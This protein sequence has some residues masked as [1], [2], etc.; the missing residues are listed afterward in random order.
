M[1]AALGYALAQSAVGDL[2]GVHSAGIG[3]AAPYVALTLQPA[4][5]RVLPRP[6]VWMEVMKQAVAVP[7]FAT[8]IWLAWV[9]AQAYGADL[10][11][12]LLASFPAA[13]DCG[14]VPG[15]LAGKGVGKR[16]GGGGLAG[17]GGVGVLWRAAGAR[18]G[19]GSGWKA[20]RKC[21][22]ERGWLGALVCGWGERILW[23]RGGRCL[24]TLPRAG[25]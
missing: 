25:A 5:T 7:I 19:G 10:L 23:R 22:C 17:S 4:W 21:E 11:A 1:G 6:G 15:A 3:V 9:L 24:W 20:W 14:V 13:G 8:V 12:A 2:R 16:G 18:G